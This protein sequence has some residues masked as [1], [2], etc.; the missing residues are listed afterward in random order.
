MHFILVRWLPVPFVWSLSG[1]FFFFFFA[2]E[3]TYWMNTYYTWGTCWPFHPHNQVK[4]I[5]F[6]EEETI[7]SIGRAKPVL[8]RFCLSREMIGH[9][10][11][12]HGLWS[13]TPQVSAVFYRLP[14]WVTVGQLLSLFGSPV[15]H[16]DSLLGLLWR[17][18]EEEVTHARHFE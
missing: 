4:S 13:Q 14:N 16:S 18:S 10:G 9:D 2:F 17:V 8:M 6:R 15:P 11:G 1:F 3:Q 7:R 12:K 5:H